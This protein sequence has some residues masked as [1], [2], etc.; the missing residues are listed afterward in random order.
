MTKLYKRI[1]EVEIRPD[2][3]QP[4][5]LD[6]SSRYSTSNLRVSF[7]VRKTI[8]S[9]A[10]T[11]EINLYNLAAMTRGNIETDG[12]SVSLV[13]G[14]DEIRGQIYLGDIDEITHVK[15][16]SDIITK[17]T[18][19]DGLKAIK[20]AKLQKTY[21]PK[22]PKINLLEDILAS[23]EGV[24]K[25]AWNIFTES[26]N[27]TQSE[28]ERTGKTKWKRL[29]SKFA[30]AFSASGYSKKIMDDFCNANN[31]DWFIDNGNLN[32]ID[33]GVPLNDK[34]IITPQ[35]GLIGSPEKTKDGVKFQSLLIPALTVGGLVEIKS[36]FVNGDFRLEEITMSGDNY[37][38][39]FACDCT[40]KALK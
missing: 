10:N 2:S 39:Q 37:G 9:S 28:L 12:D 11:A 36:M 16:G 18:C 1:C 13:A 6:M 5:S 29:S 35:S 30:G 23:M 4:V 22:L 40:C 17:I 15:N 26:D 8:K 34:F 32:I 21:A 25:G 19:G 27:R 38:G 24:A 31:L 20:A 7:S 33:K 3:G 14:Y